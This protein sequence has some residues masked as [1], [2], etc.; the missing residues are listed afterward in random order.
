MTVGTTSIGLTNEQNY[1]GGLGFFYE[2]YST[3]AYVICGRS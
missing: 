3:T 1:K 2:Y